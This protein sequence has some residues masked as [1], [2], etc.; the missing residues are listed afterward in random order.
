MKPK[1]AILLGSRSDSE[2]LKEGFELLDHLKVDYSLDIISA[3][4][5]PD[6]LRARCKQFEKENVKAVIACAG[7][8]AAL[9]G[10][11]AA[12][13]DVPVIGVPLEGGMLDGLDSL[14]AIVQVPKG[15]GLVSTGP[16]KKGF[17][18]AIIVALEILSLTDSSYK[19]KLQECK[20]KYKG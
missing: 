14:L 13:V 7:L 10:F 9:P 16:G 3:H 11:V 20:A 19:A 18:N 8:A 5:K 6:E 12:Y 15:L 2:K 17:L 1:I 4:R